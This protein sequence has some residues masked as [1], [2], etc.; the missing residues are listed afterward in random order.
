M[1]NEESKNVVTWM[2]LGDPL[3]ILR[4]PTAFR[5]CSQRES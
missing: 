4:K 3:A 5:L 2:S 1:R